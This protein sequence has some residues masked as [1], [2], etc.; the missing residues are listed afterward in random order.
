MTA[1]T[2]KSDR[3]AILE[4]IDGIFQAYIRR[5]REAIQRSHTDDWVGFL[6]PS[7]QIERG[8][9]AYMKNANKSFQA[10]HGTGYEIL[11]TEEIGR[12]HV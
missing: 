1:T 12:A 9:D 8:I 7:T 6:G 5:D 10:F 2:G 3:D 11:D 4:H